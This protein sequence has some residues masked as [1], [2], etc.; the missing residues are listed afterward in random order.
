MTKNLLK[1]NLIHTAIYT[2]SII[3]SKGISVILTPWFTK[4]LDK[5]YFGQ[6]TYL[7]TFIAFSTA[8]ISIGFETGYFY[9]KNK[10]KQENVEGTMHL[11]HGLF[12]LFFLVPAF[13]WAEPL[14]ILLIDSKEFVN[15]FRTLLGIM[16]FDIL[17]LIPMAVL[18]YKEKVL[19]YSLIRILNALIILLFTYIFLKYLPDQK[20]LPSWIPFNTFSQNDLVFYILLANLIASGIQLILLLPEIIKFRWKWKF[21]LIKKY[22]QYGIP[23]AIGSMAYLINEQADTIFL[24]KMLEDGE[25]QI[26]IYKANYRV[27]LLLGIIITGYRMGIEPFFFNQADKAGAKKNYSIVMNIFVIISLLAGLFIVFNEFW[28]KEL[29]IKDRSYHEGFK[30]VPVLI[31]AIVF[32]GIY[33]NLSVWYKINNQ[34]KYGMT[35]T[36]IGAGITVLLNYIL[37]PKYGYIASA[38]IT[39]FCYFIMVLLS[40]SFGQKNYP[41]D[42]KIKRILTYILLASAL[43]YLSLHIEYTQWYYRNLLLIPFLGLI[44]GFERKTLKKIRK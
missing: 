16:A 22:Y 42:Y 38:W 15:H 19:R 3:L 2:L 5:E 13:I 34:T 44:L 8:I 12:L 10:N 14:S 35:F 26:G 21:E 17:S 27:A 39:L 43:Y 37:V 18:R 40:Y 31:L 36:L 24:K 28:I 41:I 29:Y 23:I 1:R 6:M 30:I 4:E 7:Y 9:F 25:A 20:A 32:S 33:S 11:N